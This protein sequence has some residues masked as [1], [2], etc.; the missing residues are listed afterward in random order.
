VLSEGV[1]SSS[2]NAQFNYSTLGD[3]QWSLA[4]TE[5]GNHYK[6]ISWASD[7]CV[8]IA[9]NSMLS[10]ARAWIWDYNSDPSQ[11]FDLVDAGDGWFKIK[12]VRS[13]LYLS[14]VGG[15]TENGAEIEQNVDSGTSD[16][17]WK[18]YPYR[19]ATAMLAYDNVDCPVADLNGQSGGKGWNGGWSDIS[20]FAARRSERN[21]N[22]LRNDSLRIGVASRAIP[23]NPPQIRRLGRYL[24][25]SV[26]GNFGVYGYL[27]S[28]GCVGA[29]GTTLYISF[30][31]KPSKNF[32]FHGLE[33]N[34]GANRVACIG[35]DPDTNIINFSVTNETGAH[36]DRGNIN[37]DFYVMR[38][39]FKPGN[40]DVRVYR[41]PKSDSEPAE[42]SLTRLSVADMSFNRISV[43]ENT[44]D[45]SIK[46]VQIRLANSWQYAVGAAPEFLTQPGS[47]IVSDDIF[48]HVRVSGEVLYGT[49]KTYFLLDGSIGFRVMLSQS[50]NFQPGDVLDVMGLVQRKNLFVELIEATARK[51]GH[52]PLPTPDG[53]VAAGIAP[54]TPWIWVE[55]VLAGLKDEGTEQTLEMQDG[56]NKFA[57]RIRSV[58]GGGLDYVIGSRLKLTGVY[59]KQSG[60]PAAGDNGGSFELLLNSPAGIELIARPPWWTLER[61]LFVAAT[62]AG[63]LILAFL[64]ISQLRRQVE[65]RTVELR[66]EH[67]ARQQ[68]EQKRLVEEERARIARDIHDELGSKLTHINMLAISGPGPKIEPDSTAERMQQISDTARSLLISLDRVVWAVNPENDTLSSLVVYMAAY[69]EEFLASTNIACR[70]HA[71]ESC[72]EI[73]V[74]ADLR[75]NLLLSV[76]EAINN[77]VSHGHPNQIS[78]T[79][80]VGADSLEVQIHDNGCGFDTARTFPGNGLKNLQARMQKIGGSCRIQSS[81]T[82]GTTVALTAPLAKVSGAASPAKS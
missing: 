75:N 60:V 6:I 30:L 80:S 13:K 45:N 47:N 71:L 40:D 23:V 79:F 67:S 34:R 81:A 73:I 53:P 59:I 42:P 5:D 70:V 25:C 66:R 74:V 1:T 46:N 51:T 28:D 43:I 22:G 24:D 76:K 16:R 77:A 50:M 33:L 44:K 19:E 15:S 4:P 69:A 32:Q 8:S 38:I 64:W 54:K 3:Q 18:L 39:D 7:K 55:G 78:L 2:I 37:S 12:N 56:L 68:V 26:N 82:E 35:S 21:L 9:L 72:P 10:G 65:L 20:D 48:R 62:L 31:Q 17:L 49:G 14:V 61:V 58:P 41:N 29:D 36:I 27:D 63:G 52:L 57:A 11:Q